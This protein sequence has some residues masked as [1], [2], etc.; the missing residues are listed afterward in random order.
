M[1]GLQ[2]V[3]INEKKKCIPIDACIIEKKENINWACYM[4]LR[5]NVKLI[6]RKW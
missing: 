2:V 3:K 1:V 5:K 4:K 6:N